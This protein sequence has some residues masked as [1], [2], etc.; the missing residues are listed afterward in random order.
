MRAGQWVV[1]LL[2]GTAAIAGVSLYYLQNQYFYDRVTGVESVTIGGRAFAVSA[3]DG[4]DNASRPLRLRGCF[5]LADPEGAVAAGAP[6][7]DAEPFDAPDWFECWDAAAIDEDLKAGRAQAILAESVG[8]E[9]FVTERLI[10]IYPDGRAYQWRRIE[11][12]DG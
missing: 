4:L 9:G 5:R 6:A 11:E 3:Y 7:E 2:L 1:V 10:A 12:V 8:I